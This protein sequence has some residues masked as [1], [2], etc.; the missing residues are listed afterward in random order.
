MVPT[1]TR[2]AL[3]SMLSGALWALAWPG[4]GGLAPLA[5][6]AWLPLFHAERLHDRRTAGRRVA[7]A[8]YALLAV[9]TWN[10]A[11]SWWFFLV[12][13]PLTTRL[14]S[15]LAPMCI[16]AL[17]MTVPWWLRRWT[18]RWAGPSRATW[19]FVAYWLAFE[20]LHHGWDLQWPWFSLGNVFGEMPW[21]VQWYAITGMLG[22]SLW[23]LLMNI[24]LDRIVVRW[25][26]TGSKPDGRDWSWPVAVLLIPVAA[27]LAISGLRGPD[28]GKAVHVVVVQPNVDPYREKFGGVD[29]LDQL[30]RMLGQAEAAMTDSTVLVVLPETALQEK[31]TMDLNGWVPVLHGLWE[32]DLEASRSLQRLRAFQRRYPRAALLAGMSSGYLYPKEAT[33]P[34][35]ARLVQGTDLWYESYNAALFLPPDTA[36]QVYHKSKLVAGVELMPFEEV[37]GP[38]TDLALDLGGTTGSLGQQE[39]R[40]VLSA[41]AAGL[42]IVPAICYESVFGEHVAEHVRN[43]GDLIAIMT[44]DGW[45]GDSPGPVQHLAFASIR[46]IE[47]RRAIVRSANTGISCTVDQR[48]T[49]HHRTAWWQPAAFGAVVHLNT[50]RTIFVALGDVVGKVAVMLAL[51]A[52]GF[53][54][55]KWWRGRRD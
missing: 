27:S 52:I 50:E 5:L 10:A 4:I 12:S 40:S 43:R 8:P 35:T 33:L 54:L 28:R 17:L 2:I 37:L 14:V 26:T 19:A 34:I 21:M 29:P 16:N 48:G 45:W 7:F 36:L 49:V 32:N 30:D 44:N 15:G 13:E 1:R 41:P 51:A 55:S 47:T 23:V 11:T 22:G 9:F 42:R 6:V 53:V 25:S 3:W 20:R 46:A 31:F 39:E 38:L 18:R 24:L